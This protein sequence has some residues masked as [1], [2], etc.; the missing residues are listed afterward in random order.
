MRVCVSVWVWVGVCGCVRVC[1][2]GCGLVGLLGVCVGVSWVWAGGFGLRACVRA[3]A[4]VCVC[5]CVSVLCVVCAEFVAC[6]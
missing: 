1:A 6:N 3:S 2:R 5:V 4:C